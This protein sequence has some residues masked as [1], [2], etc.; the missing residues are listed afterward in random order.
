MKCPLLILLFLHCTLFYNGLAQA[1]ISFGEKRNSPFKYIYKI[2]N[3]EAGTLYKK[4]IEKIDTTYLHTFLDSI[5]YQ[6]AAN[7]STGHY[8]ILYIQGNTLVHELHSVNNLRAHVINNRTDLALHLYDSLGNAI[9]NAKVKLDSKTINYSP[10]SS[11]Y[12]VKQSNSDGILEIRFNG[13]TTW[14]D[15]RNNQDAY[16]VKQILYSAPI[17]YTWMPFRDIAKS[18]INGYPY[19]SVYNIKRVFEA[20][21]WEKKNRFQGYIAFNKPIY[22]PADTVR[23]KAF[24]VD[25]KGRPLDEELEAVLVTPKGN[26]SMAKLR[27]IHKGAYIYEFVL[28][29]SLQLRLDRSYSFQL[30]DKEG[31]SFMFGQFKYE[32]YEL[33]SATYS[34]R[35]EFQKHYNG[36]AQI[37]YLKAVDA[38]EL[39]LPDVRIRLKVIA[40]KASGFINTETFVADT[41]WQHEQH[42]EAAGET[43]I[44]I[45]DSIFPPADISYTVKTEFLDASNELQEKQLKLE[46]KRNPFHVKVSYEG[47]SLRISPFYKGRLLTGT[48]TLKALSGR[49]RPFTTTQT[50]IA[51]AKLPINPH[52]HKYIISNDSLEASP[53]LPG[54]PNIHTKAYRTHDSLF[55]QISNPHKL[56][57]WYTIY[58]KNKVIHRG[59]K[60][61]LYLKKK[62][63]AKDKYFVSIQYL[64][65]GNIG[66]KEYEAVVQDKALQILVD[67]PVISYPGAE[68]TINIEV[69]DYKGK[70]VPYT[71]LT[72]YAITSKFTQPNTPAVPYLGKIDPMDRKAKNNYDLNNFSEKEQHKRLK[73]LN[74]SFDSGLDS[75]EYYQ[76]LYP[77]SALTYRYIP[78][79][80][81]VTQFA[82]FI[83]ENG[84]FRPIHIIYHNGAPVY[85]SKANPN[86]PYSFVSSE[87]YH[88][89][90]LRLTDLIISLDNVLVRK[91]HKLLLAVDPGKQTPKMRIFKVKP[92]LSKQEIRLLKQTLLPIKNLPYGRNLVYIKHQNNIIQPLLS[93]AHSTYSN[94]N[95]SYQLLAGPFISRQL[96][97]V[98][99]GTINYVLPFELEPDYSYEFKAGILKMKELKK[100]VFDKRLSNYVTIP[101]LNQWIFTTAKANK[102]YEDYLF[103]EKLAWQSE[104]KPTFTSKEN[105]QWVLT[106]VQ[107]PDK[108][109]NPVN[110]IYLSKAENKKGLRVY[111]GNTTIFHQ[112]APGK[113]TI[114]FRLKDGRA[115]SKDNVEARTGGKTYLN[116]SAEALIPFEDFGLANKELEGS[117]RPAQEE[118]ENKR[119]EQA[120]LTHPLVWD[121]LDKTIY[122][123]VVSESDGLPIPGVSVNVA[124]TSIGTITDMEGHYVLATPKY[125][126]LIF[127]YIGFS[128]VEK[129]IGSD[130]SINVRLPEDVK[131]LSEVIVAGYGSS[132]RPVV[133]TPRF[134]HDLEGRVAGLEIGSPGANNQLAVRIRGNASTTGTNAPL[135]IINGVPYYGK[136]E[137]LTTAAILSLNVI[138]G[139]EATALYGSRAA[140]GVMLITTNRSFVNNQATSINEALLQ[141]EPQEAS[142]RSNFSDYAYWKPDLFTDSNGK[143]SFKIKLPDDIT[144]WNTH[145][146]AMNGNKQSGQQSGQIK[147]YKT[148]SGHLALPRFMVQGDESF[149][150]GKTMNYRTDTLSV[151]TSFYVDD[152]LAYTKRTSVSRYHLDTLRL[153]GSSTDSL[154]VR[155]MV[156]KMDGYQDGE[157]RSLPVIPRGVSESKGLFV[158]L[159]KDTTI[160]LSF[161][162]A[163]G[164]VTINTQQDLLNVFLNEIEHLKAYP[165]HCNEQVASILIA[166]LKEKKITEAQGNTYQHNLETQ[167]LIKKLEQSRSP[168]QLWGWWP[169]TDGLAWVSVHVLEALLQAEQAGYEINLPRYELIS[170][171][172]LLI[173]NEE[174]KNKLYPLQLLMRLDPKMDIRSHLEAIE[175]DTLALHE[176]LQTLKIRQE[177]KLPYSL[178]SVLKLQ[179]ETQLGNLYWHDD[180]AHPLRNNIHNTLLVYQLLRNAGGYDQLLPRI[181]GYLL[182]GRADGYWRNTFESANILSTILPDVLKDGK[183]S[184]YSRLWIGN[185]DMKEITNFKESYTMPG[186]PLSIRY[187]GK[188]PLFLTAYQ[189][190]H[191]PKPEKVEKDYIVKTY[192]DKE[193]KSLKAG[194]P[195]QLIAE[196]Q[197]KKSSDYVLI[198]IPI[199]AGCSYE[200]KTP[201]SGRETYREYYKEKTSIFCQHLPPGKYTFTISLQPRF[202]GSYTLNP[203]K[204]SL[205]YFPVFFGRNSLKTVNVNPPALPTINSTSATIN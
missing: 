94:Y 143:A 194:E 132:K 18:I 120:K 17:R 66:N 93:P 177:Y 24:I 86:A 138:K 154:L 39:A 43:S 204:V 186:G 40:T 141:V 70:P 179:K 64:L 60:T 199:P 160:Q 63:V 42:L 153:K 23:L 15:L 123:T 113:Y 38:N 165:Y 185:T 68:T 26:K 183:E 100:P 205:M 85:F 157:E 20:D 73:D 89:I 115:F 118:I 51:P 193:L 164:N 150:I 31:S 25:R 133:R 156:D 152:S 91:G 21:F 72:A 96:E 37:L 195:A 111:A 172:R 112:V 33:K 198:E 187:E 3:K 55:V 57:I 166:H 136:F 162:P 108:E 1:Q 35:G 178:D 41:L 110:N 14:L 58:H 159:D 109:N 22:K 74:T 116:I 36:Q 135:I 84:Q 87:G 173:E 32:D 69:R 95:G 163:L 75:L 4:G 11:S 13:H 44:L 174:G 9:H 6:R 158:R 169:Q 145:V 61:E 79:P 99:A 78:A 196:V 97:Y 146:L 180:F 190:Y 71:D 98:Q 83:V 202:T 131:Q 104:E 81:S 47:G 155:Y 105:G 203:A 76:F 49:N 181:Q 170:Q 144:G 119:S 121:R 189:T 114:Y 134:V 48:F 126:S 149:I 176:Y 130:N 88:S 56:P 192:F 103:E 46:Y 27:P 16:S 107:Y 122:G 90:R 140:N 139:E 117:Y 45:P 5:P 80:D 2:D 201:A 127:S 171:S 34:I 151:Q 167:R 28:H 142:I 168:R 128:S 182:E 77:D 19:G 82:P 184:F 188:R 8:L 67:Q 52:V 30:R 200:N 50:I 106:Q 161:D 148:L 92:E 101:S 62:A 10:T 7:L 197:V 191:V 175:R 12:L 129:E 29:D 102:L 59:S 54:E 124:G 137:D 147:S 125:G 53:D 65:N